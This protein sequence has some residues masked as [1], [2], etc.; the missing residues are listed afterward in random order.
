MKQWNH[1]NPTSNFTH[2]VAEDY[3]EIKMEVIK[4]IIVKLWKSYMG[5]F[6]WSVER[7][8]LAYEK[9]DYSA[10]DI[11]EFEYVETGRP[12]WCT[13]VLYKEGVTKARIIEKLLHNRKF[14][15]SIYVDQYLIENR[16]ANVAAREVL[17]VLM[18]EEYPWMNEGVFC[19]KVTDTSFWKLDNLVKVKEIPELQEMTIGGIMRMGIDDWNKLFARY[20]DRLS[21]L[22]ESRFK[23]Y[24]DSCCEQAIFLEYGGEI[25]Y[26]IP[27]EAFL[28]KDWEM[29]MKRDY[30]VNKSFLKNLSKEEL[31]ERESNPVINA[32][33]E[34]MIGSG[35]N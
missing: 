7:I 12:C 17:R 8:I 13:S 15:H 35:K 10:K 34:Q 16:Y 23:I 1:S 9:L 27:L 30:E 28:K 18:F 3:S 25:S 29:F 5:I 24:F 31:R 6:G 26:Y 20:I 19:K 2:H 33:K 14:E 4:P 21:E 22:K 11:V 32:F